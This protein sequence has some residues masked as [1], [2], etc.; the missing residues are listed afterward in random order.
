MKTKNF[1]KS[2]TIWLN[3]ILGAT[4]LFNAD[5]FSAIGISPEVGMSIVAKV[6]IFGN[7]V[8]RFVSNSEITTAGVL[9]FLKKK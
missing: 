7:F 6:A 1:L 9:D 5:L 3:L 2:K 4:T 8:L